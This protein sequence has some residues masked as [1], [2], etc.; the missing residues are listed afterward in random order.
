LDASLLPAEGLEAQSLGESI[1]STYTSRENALFNMYPLLHYGMNPEDLDFELLLAHVDSRIGLV[2]RTRK[3]LHILKDSEITIGAE[4]IRLRRGD[5]IR[6]GFTY[7]YTHDQITAFLDICG[8]EILKTFLSEDQTNV[9][10]LA[11]RST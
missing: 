9:I 6:M 3:H 11:K 10:I 8:F 4:A 7:K 2:C 5:V 1:L